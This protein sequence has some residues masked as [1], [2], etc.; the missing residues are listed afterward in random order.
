MVPSVPQKNLG[1][2]DS[3]ASDSISKEFKSTDSGLQHDASLSMS[4]PPSQPCEP[5]SALVAP[6]G[7]QEVPDN[8]SQL[9]CGSGLHQSESKESQLYQSKSL[10]VFSDGTQE[11]QVNEN[12]TL[13]TT[14][15]TSH[16]RNISEQATENHPSQLS[17][18]REEHQGE[19]LDDLKYDQRKASTTSEVKLADT[20]DKTKSN[21]SELQKQ[22]KVVIQEKTDKIQEQND[23]IQQKN[24]TIQ[25]LEKEKED[26]EQ[27]HKEKTE[28]LMQKVA[29]LEKKFQEKETLENDPE[30]NPERI[31]QL[32]K[33]RDDMRK[34]RDDVQRKLIKTTRIQE[35]KRNIAEK[36]RH[37]AEEERHRAEE[38]RHE[39]VNE[40]CKLEEENLSLRSVIND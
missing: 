22:M 40:K 33:E 4:E 16:T 36:K 23:I 2:S 27:K 29:D 14:T 15:S 3:N 12:G 19:D 1:S 37:E 13:V 35:E 26:N 31:L 7:E 38:E 11:Q 30:A 25:Q 39:A 8:V 9:P 6:P 17:L 24:T 28:E 10:G 34:E 21:F 5:F 18:S 20:V 32:K